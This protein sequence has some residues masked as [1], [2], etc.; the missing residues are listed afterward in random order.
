[1][2]SSPTHFE[3]E[4]SG[5]KVAMKGIKLVKTGKDDSYD[6]WLIGVGGLKK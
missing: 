4:P 1:M 2:N 6:S 5:Q 3:A